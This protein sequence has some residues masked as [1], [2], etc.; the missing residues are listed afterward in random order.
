MNDG[1]DARTYGIIPL[2]SEGEKN[3]KNLPLPLVTELA[4]IPIQGKLHTIS[5]L[6]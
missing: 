1:P 6:L 4:L 5:W 3:L 2:S